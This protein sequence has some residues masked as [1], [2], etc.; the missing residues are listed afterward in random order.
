MLREQDPLQLW[1]KPQAPLQGG[2]SH[3]ARL[4]PAP[5]R[6]QP[7]VQ[8]SSVERAVSSRA[9]TLPGPA[10]GCPV[11]GSQVSLGPES[12]PSKEPGLVSEATEGWGL[13]SKELLLWRPAC[14]GQPPAAAEGAISGTFPTPPPHAPGEK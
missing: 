1:P 7:R 2:R 12:L 14:R 8:L 5:M 11:A 13:A 10:R 4:P 3:R 9:R 6:P